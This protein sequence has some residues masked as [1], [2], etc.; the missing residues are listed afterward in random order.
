MLFIQLHRL[1]SAMPLVSAESACSHAR[2]K[3]VSS[4]FAASST[5]PADPLAVALSK[6]VV[7]RHD[8]HMSSSP[9]K[10]SVCRP[11]GTNNCGLDL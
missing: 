7:A 1:I 10:T 6:V 2:C 11:T 3:F 9:I 4:F 5:Q 8:L